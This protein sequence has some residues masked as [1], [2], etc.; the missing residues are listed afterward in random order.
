VSLD[1]NVAQGGSTEL[2]AMILGGN[3]S[4]TIPNAANETTYIATLRERMP[5]SQHVKVVIRVRS[6]Q[7]SLAERAQCVA[8]TNFTRACWKIGL[9]QAFVRLQETGDTQGPHT[10]VE[11]SKW[12]EEI[13][14]EDLVL[15]YIQ[16]PAI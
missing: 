9:L 15:R 5:T 11:P 4:E 10:Q 12:Q 1:L 8:S 2:S 6:Q 7:I 14:M 16:W 3:F 13:N